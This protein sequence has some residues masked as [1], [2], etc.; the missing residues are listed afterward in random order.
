MKD[1]YLNPQGNLFQR[2]HACWFL[3]RHPAEFASGIINEFMAQASAEMVKRLASLSDNES[4]RDPIDMSAAAATARN[5]A[6]NG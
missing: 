6:T 3:F 1:I 5:E 4:T 2:I